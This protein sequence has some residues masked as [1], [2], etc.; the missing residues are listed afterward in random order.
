MAS[1]KSVK[2]T[3]AGAKAVV[4]PF[5]E[6]AFKKKWSGQ[7]NVRQD[8]GII[9]VSNHLTLIDPLVVGHFLV[10]QGYL[11]HFMAKNSMFSWPIVG[12]V[13]KMTNQVPVVRGSSDAGKSIEAAQKIID[14]PNA[15]LIIYPEGTLTKDPDLWPMRGY[16]GAARLALATGA[17]VVPVVHWGDHRLVSPAGKKIKSEFRPELIVNA[18]PPV[19]LDDLRGQPFTKALLDEA[20]ER[21]MN[22]ITGE[23]ER[24]RGEKAPA[25]RFDPRRKSA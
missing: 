7:E 23:L 14:T 2:R 9:A 3:I 6:A 1:Q 17:A 21:I 12:Q 15:A 25:V 19:D 11:P 4:I 13:M 22:A 24:I 5:L 20:T 8:K 18:L 10:A 16:T